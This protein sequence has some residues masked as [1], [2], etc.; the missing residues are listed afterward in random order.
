MLNFSDQTRTGVNIQCGMVVGASHFATTYV[1]L[2][3]RF[4]VKAE[5]EET[6]EKNKT[7]RKPTNT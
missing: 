6:K 2:V 1:T 7:E 3:G 5:N 4:K